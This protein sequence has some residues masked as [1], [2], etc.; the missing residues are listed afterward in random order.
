MRQSTP[1]HAPLRCDEVAFVLCMEG[2]A[3]EPQALLLCESIRR[4]GGAY[5][6][7]AIVAVNPRPELEISPASEARLTQLGVRYVRAALNRTRS[8][9]LSINRIVAAAWAEALLEHDYLVVLDSDMAFVREPEFFRAGAGVRP[10]DVKG[11]AS[12]GAGD[13]LD[14]YWSA[15]CEIAGI[16]ADAL[17][18]GNAS[19]DG[20]RVRASYNGGF[21][22][23]RRSL[24]IF[25]ET[26]RV[27]TESMARDM[28]PLR[29]R[30]FNIFA[31][32]GDVG[33]E[34]SEWWGSSQA[35][36]S[37]AI[38]A[39]TS[40]VRI[41]DGRYNV[42][43]H[44]L[45]DASGNGFRWPVLDP[46]LVHYHWLLAR[47]NEFCRRLRALGVSEEFLAWLPAR[48]ADTTQPDAIANISPPFAPL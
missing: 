38:H 9:Y 42:P 21:C 35:A 20:A 14:P 10:V 16:S 37:V 18:Y 8:P 30:G 22:I 27:F 39:R 43:V 19:I 47:E 31:S 33:T 44:L 34:A 7:A 28:R 5:S 15:I 13:P 1:K 2:T 24:G 6:T 48:L 41:Y 4:F 32:T 29:G 40:D 17:P 36:L 11:S 26:R 25:E 3:I 45:A 46:V 12:A 23:A